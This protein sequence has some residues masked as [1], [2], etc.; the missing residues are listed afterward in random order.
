MNIRRRGFLRL[1]S[2]QNNLNILLGK[3]N[4]FLVI[5]C[6]LF[7]VFANLLSSYLTRDGLGKAFNEF[8][9]AGVLIGSGMRLDVILNFLNELVARLLV[10]GKNDS[11]LYDLTSRFI[12]NAR[13][14]TFEIYNNKKCIGVTLSDIGASAAVSLGAYLY[15][16]NN[17]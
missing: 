3:V 12:G 5:I 8:D 4:V 11:S 7:I 15:A 14:S 10:L 9:L 17:I 16:V 13:D 6:C 2:T 1:I